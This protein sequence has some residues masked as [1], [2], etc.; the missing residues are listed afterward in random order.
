MAVPTS[1][2]EDAL[3]AYML[4]EL[5]DVGRA[6]NISI[7]ASATGDHGVLTE[8]VNDVLLDLGIDDPSTVVGTVAIQR[9]RAVAAVHAWRFAKKRAASR[10]D[11]SDGSTKLSRSQLQPMI[12][13]SLAQAERIA[14]ALGV[15]TSGAGV[16]RASI[17]RVRYPQN[18][19][20]TTDP[21][22]RG[23]LPPSDV[24]P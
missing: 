14:A 20:Q 7:T 17:G 12:E 22:V 11:F 4:A 6:F 16:V 10:Y 9:L 19:Y 1:Y 18:P 3:A 15:P 5:D 13:K 21:L 23:E 2:D 24:N 8:A